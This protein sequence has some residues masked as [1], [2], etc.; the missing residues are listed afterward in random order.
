MDVTTYDELAREVCNRVGWTFED[1]TD[2]QW[3]AVRSAVNGALP[4]VW[5][6]CW[7]PDTMRTERMTL[8]DAWGAGEDYVIGDEVYYAGPDAYFMCALAHTGSA[9]ATFDGQEWTT[10]YA[11]WIRVDEPA[12]DIDQGSWTDATAYTLGQRITFNG[13][14]YQCLVAHT[15]STSLLPVDSAVWGLVNEFDY[16]VQAYGNGRATIGR[17]RTAAVLHPGQNPGATRLDFEP[18][19]SGIRFVVPPV[20]RPWLEYRMRCPQLTG[21][22][23]DA[24]TSYSVA[25]GAYSA[26]ANPSGT[27]ASS[28]Q[29]VDTVTGQIRTVTIADGETTIS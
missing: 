12:S 5:N 9:P 20:P 19:D 10:D 6:A 8:R 23:W 21:A 15:S 25:T 18:M 4:K 29:L 24:A 28:L 13:D 7:H 2:E 26:P 3:A 27:P 14:T 11:R 22:E 17:V 16:T 1:L